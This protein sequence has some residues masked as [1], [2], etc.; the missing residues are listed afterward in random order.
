[1]TKRENNGFTLIEM[2]IIVVIIG[3]LLA[4]A[5]P[6]LTNTRTIK[7]NHQQVVSTSI[8]PEPNARD[9]VVDPT[10]YPRVLTEECL[11][12]LAFIRGGNGAV[13]QKMGIDGLPATCQ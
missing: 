3:I 12:G 5:W 9:I 11:N 8:E 1:M 13:I 2:M 4:V 6:A 10:I 7:T